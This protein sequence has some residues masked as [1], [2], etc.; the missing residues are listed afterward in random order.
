MSKIIKGHNKVT[1]RPPD[2]RLK[3]NCRKKAECPMEE[4][5]QASDVVHN[6]E[7]IRPLQKKVYLGLAAGE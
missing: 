3:C 7:V 2:Q 4:N 1:L 5:C 6:C